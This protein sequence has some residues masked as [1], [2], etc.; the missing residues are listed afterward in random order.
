V[1]RQNLGYRVCCSHPTA[2]RSALGILVVRKRLATKNFPLCLW[3]PLQSLTHHMGNRVILTCIMSTIPHEHVHS[4][5]TSICISSTWRVLH[6]QNNEL[7]KPQI[8]EISK[9]ISKPILKFPHKAII[10]TRKFGNSFI[11]LPFPLNGLLEKI[12][13]TWPRAA[14]L[15]D[16][17]AS[18]PF[19]LAKR[20]P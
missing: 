17:V 3:L 5:F 8:C 13:S 1:P 6:F 14:N 20:K 15:D 10:R 2:T 9:G 16:L 19:L 11:S 18:I 7:P 4:V 12:L